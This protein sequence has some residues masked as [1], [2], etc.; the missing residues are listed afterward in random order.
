MCGQRAGGQIPSRGL[1]H[2]DPDPLVSYASHS[3]FPCVSTVWHA[4][5]DA[6]LEAQAKWGGGI[7]ISQRRWAS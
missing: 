7:L 3:G 4:A 1:T 5:V 2:E 6:L